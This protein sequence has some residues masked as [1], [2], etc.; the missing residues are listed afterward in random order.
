M[1]WKTTLILFLAVIAVGAYLSL[2]EIR[3]PLPEQRSELAR[4]ILDLPID[5]ATYISVDV[6]QLQATF[7]KQAGGWTAVPQGW[8]VDETRLQP[9]LSP[10]ASLVANRTMTPGQQPLDLSS[11]GLQPPTGS[12]TVTINGAPT[13]LLFGQMTPIKGQQYLQVGDRPHVFVVSSR[14]FESANQPL[15][16]F[17]DRR[18][19]RFIAWQTQALTIASPTSTTSLVRRTDQ[20][21]IAAPFQDL[22]DREQVMALVNGLADVRIDRFADDAPKV[23]QLTTWGFDTPKAEVTLTLSDL[24]QPITFFFGRAVPDEPT[25]VYAKRSDEP[26]IYGVPVQQVDALLKNPNGL[27]SMRVVEFVPGSVTKIDVTRTRQSWAIERLPMSSSAAT[28]STTVPVDATPRW[29]EAS[30]HT[31]LDTTRVETWLNDLL[32]MRLA[33]VVADPSGDLSHFG[34]LTPTG[35]ITIWTREGAAPQRIWVGG[36]ADQPGERYVRIDGRAPIVRVPQAIDALLSMTPEQLRLVASD[37]PST[38]A[39]SAPDHRPVSQPAPAAPSG[40]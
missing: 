22:A 3:Q 39:P 2:Y 18:L 13:T 16:A 27:R 6:P 38:V 26:F 34:L 20:W 23:E 5:A 10:L 12:L 35:S 37:Q 28:S 21:S 30:T 29:Q 33:G 36:P 19:V 7:A 11:Y 8:R 24:P 40:R 4:H 17:R 14:L 15:E 32:A 9:L 31:A 1:R 25:L